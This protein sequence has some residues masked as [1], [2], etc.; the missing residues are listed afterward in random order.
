LRAAVLAT[1]SI[2]ASSVANVAAPAL[3]SPGVPVFP[4][5]EIRQDT[6]KC[7][8]GYVD[9]Q[10]RTAF[11]AGHCRGSGNVGDKEGNL[12]GHQALFRDN[13]PDGATITTDHL[14]ARRAGQQ[15]PAGWSDAVRGPDGG[16]RAGATGLPLRSRDR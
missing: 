13:T 8:L 11:T 9:L 16:A 7:T 4:G 6:N 5:M 15:S 3:A 14:G 12:I 1:V 10:T 2:V